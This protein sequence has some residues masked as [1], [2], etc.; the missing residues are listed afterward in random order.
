MS[1]II[2]GLKVFFAGFLSVLTVLLLCLLLITSLDVRSL[3]TQTVGL[4]S[5][6]DLQIDEPVYVDLFPDLKLQINN[7]VLDDRILTSPKNFIEIGDFSLNMS[8]KQLLFEGEYIVDMK[9]NDIDLNSQMRPDEKTTL[10]RL[11]NINSNVT[12]RISGQIILNGQGES[13]DSLMKSLKGSANLKLNDGQWLGNDIWHQLRVAR[14]IY[15]RE[16]SPEKNIT[17]K[18]NMFSV[19]A[20]GAINDS[21]FKNQVFVMKMPFTL[22]TGR[23][24]LSLIDGSFDYSI[25]ATFDEGLNSILDLSVDELLDFSSASIPIRVRGYD[26]S[27]SF[28]PDIEEIF[29]EEVESTFDKQS[30]HIKEAIRKNLFN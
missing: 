13:I 4:I 1:V 12:G 29:R 7:L 21:V 20:I 6:Y 10:D 19:E 15:K 30:D 16:D 2:K 25:R 24:E 17:K 14:S 23:G 22:I 26:E 28:R 11:L 27:I 18:N 3:L 8:T 9:F 5:D